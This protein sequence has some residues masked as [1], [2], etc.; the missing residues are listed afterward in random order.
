MTEQIFIRKNCLNCKWLEYVDDT[1][2]EIQDGG[3]CCNKDPDELVK[4]RMEKMNAPNAKEEYL[5][6]SKVC[7]EMFE[8][9]ELPTHEPELPPLI[10]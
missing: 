10:Y 1:S 9:I 7:F 6:K 8:F 2:Y 3:Y 4:G 5:F